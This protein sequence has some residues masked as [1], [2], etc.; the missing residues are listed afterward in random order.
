MSSAAAAG[1]AVADAYLIA[2]WRLR[3][4]WVY[5]YSSRTLGAPRY[6]VDSSRRRS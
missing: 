3:M 5:L 2:W 6:A 4:L 1:A